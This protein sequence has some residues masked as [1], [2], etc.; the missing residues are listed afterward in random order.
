MKYSRFAKDRNLQ[1]NEVYELL[2]SEDGALWYRTTTDTYILLYNDTIDSKE[3]IR[4]TIAHELGH[5]VLKHNE[6]TDKTILSRYSLTDKEY[7]RFETE[8][9]FF[10]K[11][12][13]VPFPVLGNYVMFFH[14]MDADFIRSVFNVSYTVANYVIKNLN[15]MKSFGL[16]KDG[17]IVEEKF[18]PYIA[19]SQST[20]ICKSCHSKINRNSSF[21]HICSMKQYKGLTTLEAYLE[22]REMERVRMRYTKFNL[23]NDGIP[24]K[25]PRCEN[26]EL[27]RGD[28]C[29]ICGAYTKNICIGDYDN[30]FDILGNPYPVANFLEDGCKKILAG[31]SR[32][33][34]D[35]GGKSTYYFQGILRNWDIEKKE[36]DE[37][38]F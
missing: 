10:A 23:N 33:C 7:N 15:S 31:N 20:R 26:E 6:K 16:V 17:H 27:E 30:N 36:F 38:T 8:A 32:Y 35:C 24:E 1:L 2:Q 25:C 21:C 37:M 18:L 29:N 11:H 14:R 4:F 3:R 22:N 5:Y 9:N 13:L 19:T 12:L 28:Y 34:P